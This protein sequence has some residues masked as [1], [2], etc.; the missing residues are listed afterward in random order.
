MGY[1]RD[2]LRTQKGERFLKVKSQID[3]S[4]NGGVTINLEGFLDK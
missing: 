1:K 2:L 3:N 4:A